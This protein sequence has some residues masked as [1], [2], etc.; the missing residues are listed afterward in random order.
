MGHID[1][2]DTIFVAVALAL[3][4]SIWSDDRHFKKQKRIEI[5][6]TKDIFEMY[7]NKNED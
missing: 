7:T 3:N 6:T 1:K 2:K 5:F 4:C